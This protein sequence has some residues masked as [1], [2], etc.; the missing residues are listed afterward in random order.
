MITHV[1]RFGNTALDESVE[2]MGICMG[3]G[4]N[5][6]MIIENAVPITHGS[7]IEVGFSPED[8]ASF[9]Q[10]DEQYAEK[11][12]YAI[13]W[14]HSHPGW[15]LFFSEN[16]VKNHLFYQKKQTPN[17]FGIVFDHN[18][19]GKEGSLGFEIYRLK[20]L[21]KGPKSD[22]IRVAYEVE[23]PKT[24][25]YYKWVQK[26]VEDSQKKAP[27]LIKEINE[28]TEPIPGELQAIPGAEDQLDEGG[29]EDK[30]PEI[31]P[32]ISG[33]TEGTE[34]FTS[35]FLDVLKPQLGVWSKDIAKGTLKGAE[36]M[37][38]TLNQMK[39]AISFGMNK[40][41]NWFDKNLAEVMDTFKEDISEY[42]N[43]R[44]NA[45]KELAADMPN[46]KDQISSAVTTLIQ[47]SLKENISQMEEKVK[48]TDQKLDETAQNSAKLAELITS[49]SESLSSIGNDIN[50]VSEGIGKAIEDLI[51]PLEETTG[52]EI[53]KLSTELNSVKETYTKMKE[54]FD[55]LQKSIMD[56]RNL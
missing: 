13:G 28:I 24:L 40:V 37:R 43:T 14:Y 46:K 55:K 30:H 54:M 56:L 5:N 25:D 6:K 16:D 31:T 38:S 22:Y 45:Q 29:E 3:K 1:L 20:D 47:D 36:S 4:S 10:I 50:K 26:F 53:E 52:T 32:I 19:M 34:K 9:A 49:N 12:L 2:V 51:T 39:E 27:I 33:F 44:M 41:Q 35:Q 8:Y 18:L 23:I 42:L 17:A 7:R 11:G 48:N 21:K 15:G